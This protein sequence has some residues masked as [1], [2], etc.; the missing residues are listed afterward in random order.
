MAETA[1]NTADEAK[2]ASSAESKDPSGESG[3]STASSV[4]N[5]ET[6]KENGNN[7]LNGTNDETNSKTARNKV[8]SSAKQIKDTKHSIP[9]SSET[10]DKESSTSEE[11][12]APA[13]TSVDENK[14]RNDSL[15]TGPIVSSTKKTRPPYKFDPEKVVL[16]FLFANR[17]GLTVTVECKPGDT[18]GEVKAQLLSVWPDGK[19]TWLLAVLTFRGRPNVAQSLSSNKLRSRRRS[20]V[21]FQ[22]ELSGNFFGRHSS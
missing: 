3:P 1:E 5:D 17:D 19:C 14:K 12:K 10:K 4:T 20:R 16:R 18:V 6:A 8:A 9:D 21:F 15:S 22:W 2:N 11:E 13:A 7:E